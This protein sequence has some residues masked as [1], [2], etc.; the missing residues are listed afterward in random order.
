MP[1]TI[2]HSDEGTVARKLANGVTIT[3]ER[4]PHL[5]SAA[6]GVWVKTGAANEREDQAGISHF[7]EHL[8]FKGTATRSAREIVEAVEREGGQL[9]AFTSRDYTCVY[10]KTLDTHITTGIEIL[11]DI[12]KNSQF[13]DLEK[14]RNV[15]LEEIAS[16]EDVPEDHVHELLAR[17]LWPNHALGRPVSG[18]IATVATLT[19]DAIRGYYD[20]WYRPQNLYFS[21][22]GNF[23]EDAVLDLVCSEFGEMVPGGPVERCGPPEFGRGIEANERDI[24]QNHICIG[25][26]GPSV[27]NPDRYV[28]SLLSNTLGGG[29]TSRLFERIREDEG[30]AYAIYSFHATYLVSGML[31]IYAAVAPPNLPKTIDLTFAEL[32]RF[33]E[34]PVSDDELNM[35][36]EQLKGGMLI[37]LEDTF[38]RMSRMAK[39][40]MC[41]GR[42]VSLEEII[43]KLDAV[44]SDQIQ[45]VAQDIFT[46]EKCAMAALGPLNGR[47]REPLPL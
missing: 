30:L 1:E 33:R 4:L 21:I 31:G 16:I 32:R 2:T 26:P 46:P 22:A 17:R 5:R 6:A 20:T 44:T 38:V 15:V 14:E 11:A 43:D 8:F 34:E 23:D 37:A 27:D 36:R 29:S 7:L 41:F 28:Y 45:A 13:R 35:N 25:F 3:M 39:S 9:N 12:I 40:M 24:A 42:L 18:T 10:V 19:L 47:L